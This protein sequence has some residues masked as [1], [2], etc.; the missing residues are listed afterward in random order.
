MALRVVV[1]HFLPGVVSEP[2][3][4][5]NHRYQAYGQDIEALTPGGNQNLKY[6]NMST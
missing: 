5:L 2:I 3:H 6:L 4:L 1:A